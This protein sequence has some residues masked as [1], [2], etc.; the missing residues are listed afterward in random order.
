MGTRSAPQKNGR[1]TLSGSIACTG[2]AA[3]RSSSRLSCTA[4]TSRPSR[5]VRISLRV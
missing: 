5:R 4:V 2:K 3:K 1:G